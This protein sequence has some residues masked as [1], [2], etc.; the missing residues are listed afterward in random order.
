MSY[1]TIVSHRNFHHDEAWAI[2]L[3]K[4][5]GG[6]KFPGIEDARVMFVD[7]PQCVKAE[8]LIKNGE[9]CV[10]CGGGKYDEH[11]LS[12]E[13]TCAAEM[14]ANDLGLKNNRAVGNIIE[15]V[16]KCDR[17][18]DVRPQ[19]LPSLIKQ[20]HK[21][22]RDNPEVVMERT[23]GILADWL[24]SNLEFQKSFEATNP[25][26]I[27]FQLQGSDKKICY[28]VFETDDSNVPTIA[29]IKGV[30][31]VVV[32]NARGNVQIF[33]RGI[34][35]P[36]GNVP[37]ADLS[38]VVRIIRKGEITARRITGLFP[39]VYLRR[40]EKL[41][42]VPFWYYLEAGQLLLNGSDQ[43]ARGV[44]PTKLSLD[45]IIQA[46]KLG[47]RPFMPVTGRLAT[48]GEVAKEVIG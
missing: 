46:I 14:V 31:I 20:W 9:I 10:G 21:R 36:T 3:L 1:H 27:M 26:K 25:K 28:A 34:K 40:P 19:E 37:V 48:V 23:L 38:D 35:S 5:F 11:G 42:E 41:P 6:P 32:K 45:D 7:D 16:R 17:T 15:Y 24:D 33:T 4:R 22:H 47:T 2:Y 44:E 8:E 18:S 30:D 12:G 29:R 39:D 43:G 13:I